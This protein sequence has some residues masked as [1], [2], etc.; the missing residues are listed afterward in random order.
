MHGGKGWTAASEHARR[1][2]RSCA[3]G[4][5]SRS[6]SS[7]WEPATKFKH[8]F[9]SVVASSASENVAVRVSSV[10]GQY[11]LAPDTVKRIKTTHRCRHTLVPGLSAWR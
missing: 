8:P 7:L 4:R 5:W 6:F 3:Y 11:L 9:S 10:T 2:F 1:T